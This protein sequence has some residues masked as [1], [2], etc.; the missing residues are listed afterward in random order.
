MAR[1]SMYD[2]DDSD[3]EEE[4]DEEEDLDYMGIDRR[5]QQQLEYQDDPGYSCLLF[6]LV[7]VPFEYKKSPLN[8]I[9]SYV[10]FSLFFSPVI[11]CVPL[12]LFLEPEVYF[13]QTPILI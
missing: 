1:S 4:D 3:E 5:L 9:Q 10:L 7:L 12:F 13:T 2:Y 11:E 6:V 8:P